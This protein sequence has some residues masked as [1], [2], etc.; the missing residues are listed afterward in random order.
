LFELEDIR[1]IDSLIEL[2]NKKIYPHI[3]TFLSKKY[4]PNLSKDLEFFK[5]QKDNSNTYNI[6]I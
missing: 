4:I 3:K 1:T 5:L 6:K 2:I